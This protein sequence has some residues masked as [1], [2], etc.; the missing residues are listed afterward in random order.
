M[1]VNAPDWVVPIAEQAV[2]GKDVPLELLLALLQQESGFNPRAESHAG[3]QGIAQFIPTTAR[4]YGIDPWDPNQAIPASAQYL[5]NA[6]N[7]FK[8]W[9]LAL[10]AYNAGPGAVQQHGGIPPYQ[11]TQDYVQRIM[12]NVPSLNTSYAQTSTPSSSPT[13]QYSAPTPAPTPTPS[14]GRTYTVKP[15]DTLSKIAQ[16]YLGNASAYGQ[17]SGYRSGNPNLIYPGEVINIP[18]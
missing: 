6:F 17:L 10:A 7:M 12:G 5:Q 13:R 15:G 11:Q 1:A 16:Q 14:S 2:E 9:S 4:E 3:A 18:G 8:D